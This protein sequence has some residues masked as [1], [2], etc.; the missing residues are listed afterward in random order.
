M[1]KPLCVCF[2]AFLAA[3]VG[4]AG[5]RTVY[6]PDGTPV[7]LREEVRNVKV[8]VK[9]RD[10]DATPATMTLPEGWYALPLGEDD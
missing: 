5:Q 6:V 9:D 8:W 10:G 3:C 1:M 7:R 4:C 2:V